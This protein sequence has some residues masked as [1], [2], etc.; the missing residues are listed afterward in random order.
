M[1][2]TRHPCSIPYIKKIKNCSWKSTG[3]WQR[4]LPS[5]R[6][7]TAFYLLSILLEHGE[8]TEELAESTELQARCMLNLLGENLGNT[9][10]FISALT[11]DSTPQVAWENRLKNCGNFGWGY[12]KNAPALLI[13]ALA[14][15]Y[16]E[17]ELIWRFINVLLI[18]NSYQCRNK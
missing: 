11:D 17:S 9:D 12:G 4:Q 16:C 5:N 3:C 14:L 15:L 13:G 18:H 2:P 6:P 1:M 10:N 8:G 7:P